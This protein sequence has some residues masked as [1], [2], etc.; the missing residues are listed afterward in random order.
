MIDN[1]E[2]LEAKIMAEREY[3]K[4][5]SYDIS[6]KFLGAFNDEKMKPWYMKTNNRTDRDLK[7]R[8]YQLHHIKKSESEVTKE[9][10]VTESKTNN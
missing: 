7:D 6:S 10:L 9:V 8:Q 2:V 3:L 5:K 4:D 1:K